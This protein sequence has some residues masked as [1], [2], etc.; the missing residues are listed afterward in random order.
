[1][2]FLIPGLAL[3][4][5]MVYVSTRI[6]K[7]AAAA[8]DTE[9]IETD[10][11]TIQKPDGFIAIAEPSPPLLFD[12]HSKEFGEGDRQDEHLVRA[13]VRLEVGSADAA[14]ENLR[15]ELSSETSQWHIGQDSV[16]EGRDGDAFVTYR[17]AD[18]RDQALILSVRSLAEP[19]GDIA[20]KIEQMIKTF[21][22]GSSQATV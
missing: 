2:E 8:Y 22:V 13:T 14:A 19:T 6:K 17:I 7:S 16:I 20:R 3:V 1:M 15:R 18:V 12:A 11:F 5:L 10:Y 21:E 9:M 4:A